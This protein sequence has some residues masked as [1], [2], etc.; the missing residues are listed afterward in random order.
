M[1]KFSILRTIL[2]SVCLLFPYISNAQWSGTGFAIGDKYIATNH[3]VV[4]DA[5]KIEIVGNFNGEKVN[6]LAEVVASDATNDLTILKVTDATFNGFG[7]IPYSAKITSSEIG[8]NIFALGYP[9]IE[10]MGSDIKLS[11][12]IISSLSGFQ[13]NIALYQISAPIQPG[14]SGGPLFDYDGNLIG[15][16]CA[17]HKGT[18]NVN[19]AVKVSY[20]HHLV[21]RVPAVSIPSHGSLLGNL[22]LSEKVKRIK[23]FVFIVKCSSAQPETKKLSYADTDLTHKIYYTTSDNAPLK[24][25]EYVEYWKN[26]KVVSNT[27]E[28]SLGVITFNDAITTIGNGAFYACDKLTGII[29]PQSVVSISE[30]AFYCCDNLQRIAFG[31][32]VRYVGKDA[33]SNCS[34]INRVDIVSLSSWCK[35]EFETNGSTPF[36]YGETRLFLRNK[37]LTEVVI[38]DDITKIGKYTFYYIPISSVIIPNSVKEIEDGA[39]CGSSI[40]NV[41]IPD[42]VTKIGNEA[43]LWCKNLSSI[44]LGENLKYIGNRAFS[45]CENLTSITIPNGV[46]HIGEYAFQGGALMELTIPNTLTHIGKNAFSECDNLTSVTIPNSVTHIG[47]SAFSWCKALTSITIP[48]SVT[49][50]G[51]GAFDGCDGLTSVTIPNSVIHIGANPFER[52]KNL[53]AFYGKFASNDNCCLI[54]NGKLVSFAHGC[55][56]TTYSIPNN[57]T[58]IGDCAFSQCKT[59]TNVII[60]NSVTS[61]GKRAFAECGLK[62]LNIPNSVTKIEKSA[63]WWCADL[64]SVMIGSGVTSIG[65]DVFGWCDSIVAFYGKFASGD[66]CCLIVNG[67]LIKF[68]PKCGATSYSVPKG[69]TVIAYSAFATISFSAFDGNTTLKNVF[70]PEGI[71]TIEDRAFYECSALTSISIPASVTKIGKSAFYGCHNINSVYCKSRSVI[72][73]SEK[74]FQHSVSDAKPNNQNIGCDIYVPRALVSAYKTAEHWKDYAPNIVGYDL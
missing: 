1:K 17:K 55:G 58:S 31:E 34:K 11:T 47:K 65:E 26:A 45:M 20:L 12:G 14:N 64:T 50:I 48:N 7:N 23:D 24:L 68:A 56:A 32:S 43:F 33:F 37:E 19:Y 15:V 60:P 9:L 69:V 72:K 5:G 28:G 30:Y 40:S 61:I 2:F 63:F 70:L 73:G 22:T 36:G 49:H 39:F 42:S 13:D 59:L 4:K 51:G 66:S 74:M 62:H 18:E 27:Y 46:T 16:I 21:S 8:E 29:I 71:T 57:V 6:Y 10:T 52:C 3:H 54:V 41:V 35:I 38:P 53:A 25:P 44:F 67:K